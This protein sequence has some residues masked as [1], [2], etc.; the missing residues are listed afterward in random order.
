ME[1]KQKKI[2]EKKNENL[3]QKSQFTEEKAIIK[4]GNYT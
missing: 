3:N 2:N 1:E 4:L